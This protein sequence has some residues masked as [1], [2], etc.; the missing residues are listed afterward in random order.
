M[1]DSWSRMCAY[2]PLVSLSW[3]SHNFCSLSFLF[4]QPANILLDEFGHV[5]ISDLGLACDF[6][7]KKPHASVWVSRRESIAQ[8]LALF[9]TILSIPINILPLRVMELDECGSTC[10]LIQYHQMQCELPEVPQITNSL[11]LCRCL[12]LQLLGIEI[13]SAQLMHPCLWTCPTYM[14]V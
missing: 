10:F 11:A 13:I 12:V 1:E 5:R 4:L 14:F 6:S 8:P 9:F 7:K 3:F 2:V